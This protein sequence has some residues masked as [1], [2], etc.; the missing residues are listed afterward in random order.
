MNL[1]KVVIISDEKDVTRIERVI[2][3][4]GQINKSLILGKIVYGRVG[5]DTLLSFNT[6]KKYYRFMLEKLRLNNV[7][8]LTKENIVD[9][10]KLMRYK[11]KGTGAENK[12]WDDLKKRKNGPI[13]IE[14]LV[15]AGKYQEIIKA[16]KD[17]RND[18]KSVE[19]AKLRL[20][21]AV[22]IA[23]E[24]AK[25]EYNTSVTKQEESIKKL[26]DIASDNNLKYPQYSELTKNS[27]LS[28]I[29]LAGR[30]TDQL[31]KL[32]NICNNNKI[33]HL[34]P[35]MAFLKFAS[36]VMEK[37]DLFDSD[38]QYAVKKLNLRWLMICYPLVEHELESHE[39]EQFNSF[40]DHIS[41]L[42]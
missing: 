15:S 39:K 7:K 38:I 16:T 37:P 40:Y 2:A 35:I 34:G 21:E 19:D 6:D 13:D 25:R 14:N 41:A 22:I 30:Q 4:I 1:E 26:V 3:S 33:H 11:R 23:I 5:K 18:Q 29:E 20:T 10:E 24:A 8:V 28:A 17:I 36:I 32:I 42:R 12:G 27:A 9:E 31:Y